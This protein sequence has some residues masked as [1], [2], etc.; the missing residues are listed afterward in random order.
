[1]QELA[2]PRHG[3][4]RLIGID[5]HDVELPGSESECTQVEK[6]LER[7]NAAA[8]ERE[9]GQRAGRGFRSQEVR[10]HGQLSEWEEF[11]AMASHGC[12]RSRFARAR[13]CRSSASA[14]M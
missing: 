10:R 8:A 13:S 2:G 4:V 3:G 14:L 12:G 9:V 6:R 1:M 11:A 7:A 5:Q